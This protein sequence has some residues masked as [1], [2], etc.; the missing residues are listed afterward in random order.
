M[1]FRYDLARPRAHDHRGQ[2]AGQTV[3]IFRKGLA[4]GLRWAAK[5]AENSQAMTHQLRKSFTRL[6][7]ATRI[8]ARAALRCA[9]DE[10]FLYQ[11]LDD[12]VSIDRMLRVPYLKRRL[13]KAL[14][15]DQTLARLLEDPVFQAGVVDPVLDLDEFPPASSDSQGNLARGFEKCRGAPPFGR[16][17]GSD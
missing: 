2:R 13:I 15:E 12:P 5:T 6:V 11:L 7:L 8:G 9:Q 16:R 17:G 4:A 1:R 14:T 10:R 3:R